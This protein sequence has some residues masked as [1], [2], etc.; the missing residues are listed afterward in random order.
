M[1]LIG[2]FKCV[3]NLSPLAENVFV[4]NRTLF[5]GGQ[6][7]W[8]PNTAAENS[9]TAAPGTIELYFYTNYLAGT[10]PPTP[11]YLF[12]GQD[13]SNSLGQI[14]WDP[15]ETQFVGTIYSRAGLAMSFSIDMT[16]ESGEWYHLV[17]RTLYAGDPAAAVYGQSGGGL[18]VQI[19]KIGTH[20][21]AP[22]GG[23]SSGA[24][25]FPYGSGSNGGEFAFVP[26][27]ISF[28]VFKAMRIFSV[29]HTQQPFHLFC[30][31]GKQSLTSPYPIENTWIGGFAELRAWNSTRTDAQIL[32]NRSSFVGPDD[33]TTASGPVNPDLVHYIRLNERLTIGQQISAG[34]GGFVGNFGIAGFGGGGQDDHDPTPQEGSVYVGYG[35]FNLVDVDGGVNPTGFNSHPFYPSSEDFTFDVRENEYAVGVISTI[36]SGASGYDVSVTSQMPDRISEYAV[37]VNPAA[38]EPDGDYEVRTTA[39]V[40]PDGSYEVLTTTEDDSAGTYAVLVASEPTSAGQYRLIEAQAP[41]TSDG[42]YALLLLGVPTSVGSYEVDLITDSTETS[43]GDYEV[44][45]LVTEASG[46]AYE[47][48]RPYELP[49][50]A[51]QYKI[52][53]TGATETS[54]GDYEVLVVATDTNSGSYEVLVTA[55]PQDQSGGYEVLVAQAPE[56]STGAYDVRTFV[57]ETASGSYVLT[58]SNTQPQGAEYVVLSVATETPVGDYTVFSTA[59]TETSDGDYTIND[60]QPDVFYPG[61]YAVFSEADAFTVPVI[62]T[63]EYAVAVPS[64]DTSDGDYKVL[65]EQYWPGLFFPFAPMP[66]AYDVLVAYAVEPAGEY[67]IVTPAEFDFTGSYRAAQLTTLTSA[68]EYYLLDGTFVEQVNADYEVQTTN[69]DYF[70]HGFYF[71]TYEATQ[72]DQASEYAVEFPNVPV[73]IEDN[74]YAVFYF[75]IPQTHDGQYEVLTTPAAQTLASDYEVSVTPAALTSASEYDVAVPS[76]S[77]VPG[78]YYIDVSGTGLG[79]LLSRAHIL[80]LP[81]EGAAWDNVVSWADDPL[82]DLDPFNQNSNSDMVVLAAALVFVRTGDTTYRDKAKNAL[83]NLGSTEVPSPVAEVL[84]LCRN[85]GAY[86]CA[87]DLLNQMGALDA[88]ELTTLDTYFTT[89]RDSTTTSDGRSIVT[90]HETRPNNFGT[91]AGFA[92]M[93]IDKFI[94]D[95]ADFDAAVEVAKRWFGDPTSSF[96][97]TESNYGA[98]TSWQAEAYPNFFGINRLG[99]TLTTGAGVIDIDGGLPEEIRRSGVTAAALNSWPSDVN[100]QTNTYNWEAMQGATMQ[101]VLLNHQGYPAFQWSDQA[102]L[103]AHEFI[104]TDLGDPAVGDPPGTSTSDDDTWQPWIINYFYGTS[105]T[106]LE[107]GESTDAGRPGKNFG[108]ADWI[109][110]TQVVGTQLVGDARYAVEVP[111]TALVPDGEY[112][113]VETGTSVFVGSYRVAALPEISSGASVYRVLVAQT[114]ETSTGSYEVLVATDVPS[115][116]SYELIVP[117]SEAASGRYEVLV[118]R[119]ATSGGLY[120]LID[121]EQ[122][123]RDGLYAVVADTLT[124]TSGA[125]S[126]LVLGDALTVTSGASSYYLLREQGPI[127]SFGA[128]DVL[129]ATEISPDLSTYEVLVAYQIAPDASTYTIY[130]VLLA[131]SQPVGTYDVLVAYEE[132][133]GG[134]YNLVI[135]ATDETSLGQYR[136]L[137]EDGALELNK[138]DYLVQIS[139]LNAEVDGD[140]EIIENESVEETGEYRIDG[141]VD[142]VETGMFGRYQVYNCCD[143]A[144]LAY[145]KHGWTRR[146]AE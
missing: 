119:E 14:Y 25:E 76:T 3:G 108:F 2:D 121:P 130:R 41:Q 90:C 109:W 50:I 18:L 39:R 118:S 115:V 136:I 67:Q 127:V 34:G 15:T 83:L 68:S 146:R 96:N 61:Q 43:D 94:E 129:V 89:R 65:L 74:E 79:I 142:V 135:P 40:E 84:G 27:S 55:Q 91:H 19:G 9:N 38:I 51:N 77:F 22:S 7:M 140:Y 128:Y 35:R 138:G 97:F 47:V 78:V 111:Q 85:I 59:P 132:T 49:L 105:Y 44:S 125:S 12:S 60:P 144:M 58:G 80:Q 36:E 73:Q 23:V 29:Q 141:Q 66:A 16:L 1:T 57:T 137:Q 123:N 75:E 32:A 102:L 28:T 107:S 95:D 20:R 112:A 124:I 139:T 82:G 87:A 122:A 8:H 46:G 48:T 70:A 110:G 106:A 11:M 117:A 145:R 120:R 24:D 72:E 26:A 143:L 31:G 88:G 45:V 101:V 5:P 126:Y 63:N 92:R 64:T 33:V 6:T 86:V 103:R 113:I 116:G 62:G 42:E 53:G 100:P 17:I 13:G 37:A 56:E 98:D 21:D 131:D 93:M 10:S 71:V 114:P 54:D 81:A 30:L 69:E 99:T 133:S 52:A 104:T 134:A 4:A